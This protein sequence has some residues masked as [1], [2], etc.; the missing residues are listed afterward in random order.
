MDTANSMPNPYDDTNG[1]HK[2]FANKTTE[3]QFKTLCSLVLGDPE[4][5]EALISQLLE[6]T[7]PLEAAIALVQI[8]KHEPENKIR[9][10][11]VKFTLQ[12]RLGDPKNP[13]DV[14]DNLMKKFTAD[15]TKR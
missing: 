4:Q 10:D 9:L 6:Q 8:L 12:N 7:A 3:E 14:W 5:A 15:S 11:A 13:G 2:T 1:E